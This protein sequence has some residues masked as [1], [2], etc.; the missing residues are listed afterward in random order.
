MPQ[1][2]WIKGE[3]EVPLS[4]E[5]QVN[6]MPASGLQPSVEVLRFA[7]NAVAD[8]NSLTFVAYGAA[9][10]GM[11]Q[12]AELV[13]RA[14]FYTRSFD[15]LDF[16]EAVDDRQVYFARYRVVIPSGYQEGVLE[17]VSLLRTELLTFRPSGAVSQVQSN[18]LFGDFQ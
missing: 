8:W 11:A 6:W 15:P 9:V 5:I 2:S 10:S 18:A 3:G 7:D 17:D 16:G 4:F 1:V 14:G 13:P 12:M